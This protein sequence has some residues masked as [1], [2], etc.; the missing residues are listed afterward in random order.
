M[1]DQQQ[2]AGHAPADGR[3]RIALYHRPMPGGGYVDVEMD[4]EHVSEGAAARIRGRVI[5]ERRAELGRRVGHQPPVVAEMWGD[6]TD[7]LMADLFR[8]ACDN[9][10]LARSL[11]RWQS[12][13]SRA[14]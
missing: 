7:E 6:D 5:M 11:M 9:A 3:S 2:D 14:D 10:A 12:A 13:R 1:L 8:L 4:A